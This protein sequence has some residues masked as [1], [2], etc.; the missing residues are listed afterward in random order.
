MAP[1]TRS[2]TA[3]EAAGTQPGSSTQAPINLLPLQ[4]PPGFNPS[5]APQAPSGSTPSASPQA[6]SG[7]LNAQQDSSHNL[8]LSLTR[9]QLDARFNLEQRKVEIKLRRAEADLAAVNARTARENEESRAKI[10]AI[11]AGTITAAAPHS[12][13]D[14][15]EEPIGEISPATFLVANR[16]P[17]LPK[18]EIA[19]IFANKFQPE[20]LYKLRHLKGQEDKDRDENITIKNGQMKLK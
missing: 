5:P 1:G 10:A 2:V 17:G 9:E 18:A 12:P 14:E 16:Y 20:N 6:L 15:V 3:A 11:Q 19:R 7:P 4:A 13:A 8:H